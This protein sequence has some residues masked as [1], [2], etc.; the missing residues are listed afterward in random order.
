MRTIGVGFLP[1]M[2]VAAALPLELMAAGIAPAFA[3]SVTGANGGRRRGRLRTPPSPFN[4]IRVWTGRG[5]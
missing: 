4:M 5:K 1:R 2:L 3:V